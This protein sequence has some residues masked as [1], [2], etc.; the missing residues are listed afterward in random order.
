MG[1]SFSYVKL[2][3]SSLHHFAAPMKAVQTAPGATCFV[4]HARRGVSQRPWGISAQAVH[5]TLR[6]RMRGLEV[7]PRIGLVV[8]DLLL[9]SNEP[10]CDDDPE[11]SRIMI[12]PTKRGMCSMNAKMWLQLTCLSIAWPSSLPDGWKTKLLRMIFWRIQGHTRQRRRRDCFDFQS[13][14]R[15]RSFFHLMLWWRQ[16]CE[17]AAGA[18]AAVPHV[19]LEGA[20]WNLT[21]SQ[22]WYPLVIKKGN[23]KPPK[24]TGFVA[25]STINGEFSI[26]YI[27]LPDYVQTMGPRMAI[28]MFN[29]S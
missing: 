12:D 8:F 17:F 25:N 18:P 13:A 9:S 14:S 23:G 22:S 21:M 27:K 29:V 7:G 15:D 26:G 4:L 1:H 20:G 19:C 3:A 10:S 16:G 28:R 2:L 24:W 6:C 5:M 11:W